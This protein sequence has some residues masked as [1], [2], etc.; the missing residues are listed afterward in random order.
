MLD[1]WQVDDQTDSY[2]C[3]NGDLKMTINFDTRKGIIN[4]KLQLLNGYSEEKS[5]SIYRDLALADVAEEYESAMN[6]FPLK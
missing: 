6:D 3:G 4:L 2:S 1:L 5:L